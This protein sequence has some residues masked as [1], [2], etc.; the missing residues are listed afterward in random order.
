[1]GWFGKKKDP[2]DA[3][4]MLRRYNAQ[5]AER[6]AAAGIAP[7]A[8]IASVASTVSTGGGS[9]FVV[10]DVFTITGRGQ[11]ATGRT[12]T[13]A[14]R[15]GDRV[16][17]LR[18]SA[19]TGASTITGIEMFRKKADEAPVGVAAG[20]LLKPSVDLARGDVIRV[21]PTA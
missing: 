7:S 3:N 5:E 10:E 2:L 9:E 4:E 6:L 19:Q 15:T 18:G 13:G 14:M 17:V 11:V 8:G 20:L 12:T 1:M 21:T 16:V